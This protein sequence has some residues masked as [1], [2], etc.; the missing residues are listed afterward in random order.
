MKYCDNWIP[1]SDRLPETSGRYLVS[2]TDYD[3][4]NDK[5][6][7][8]VE[9]LDFNLYSELDIEFWKTDVDAWQPLPEP[10]EGDKE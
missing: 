2:R 7:H 9:V 4:V 3:G 6:V 10:W 1:C 5:I 8:F